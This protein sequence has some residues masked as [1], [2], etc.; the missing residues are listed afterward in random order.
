MDLPQ[1]KNSIQRRQSDSSNASRYSKASKSVES[2]SNKEKVKMYNPSVGSKVYKPQSRIMQF[3]TSN[4]T[5]LPLQIIKGV[6]S[7]PLSSK[8]I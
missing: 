8:V 2:S 7:R 6:Y 3:R 1:K 4:M 5:E